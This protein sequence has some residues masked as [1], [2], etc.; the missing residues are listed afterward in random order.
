MQ[1]ER[2]F[3]FA[4]SFLHLFLIELNIITRVDDGPPD[5]RVFRRQVWIF[6]VSQTL[7]VKGVTSSIVG[8]PCAE[9]PRLIWCHKLLFKHW[10]C[11]GT[12]GPIS[13]DEDVAHIQTK[14]F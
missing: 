4:P 14:L 12:L 13:I 7:L 3:G 2:G 6:R 8:L 9:F 1:R 11:V 5:A 10:S